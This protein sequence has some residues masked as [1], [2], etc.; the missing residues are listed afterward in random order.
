MLSE[1]QWYRKLS[2]GTWVLV[3][4]DLG[5]RSIFWTKLA[6]NTSASLQYPICDRTILETEVW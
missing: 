3:R 1:F 6:L 5:E 2:G 4:I